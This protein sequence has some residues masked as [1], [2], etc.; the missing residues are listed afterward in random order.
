MLTLI[1]HFGNRRDGES[2]VTSASESGP[3]RSTNL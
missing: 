2:L 3:Y 1:G